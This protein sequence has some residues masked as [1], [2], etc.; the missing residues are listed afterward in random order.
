MLPV[1]G[2]SF[3]YLV[4]SWARPTN[5]A[6]RCSGPRTSRTT[7]ARTRSAPV[8]RGGSRSMSSSRSALSRSL[9]RPSEHQSLRPGHLQ[10][11]A[12]CSAGAGVE[13][14]ID[15]PQ[16]EL[17]TIEV[18]CPTGKKVLFVRFSTDRTSTSR[19]VST[20]PTKEE[21]LKKSVRSAVT[22]VVA[23]PLLAAAFATPASAAD[24]GNVNVD[25]MVVQVGDGQDGPVGADGSC[26]V[27][28]SPTGST[29][30]TSAF[31][32]MDVLMGSLESPME[33]V[34]SLGSVG[35]ILG[36]VLFGGSVAGYALTFYGMSVETPFPMPCFPPI[37]D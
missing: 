35:S 28:D 9:Q 3:V 27:Q 19:P 12:L 32:S 6:S 5:L 29:A 13:I 10:A 20:A 15:E 2:F 21:P 14:T 30:S 33:S 8:S 7:S 22:A 11:G 24:G 17:E 25:P 26:P 18:Y 31:E 37:E 23:A 16:L 1:A 34:E 4:H 36:P